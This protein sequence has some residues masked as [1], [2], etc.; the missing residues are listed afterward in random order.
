MKQG[1]NHVSWNENPPES[2]LGK[3]AAEKSKDN[4]GIGSPPRITKTTKVTNSAQ[5]EEMKKK[6]EKLKEEER[7]VD[8]YLDYLKHQAAVYNGRQPP[9]AEHAPYLPPGFGNI[10]DQMYVRFSDVTSMPSY[11]SD[12]VIGIRAPSGTSLEVPDPDQGMMHGERRF[13][14]YL[15]SKGAEGESAKASGKGEPI[16]VYL[17]RPRADQQGKMGGRGN[18]GGFVQQTPPSQ[19]DPPHQQLPRDKGPEED[20]RD[21]TPGVFRPPS[22]PSGD[23]QYGPGRTAPR[24]GRDWDYG[25]PPYPP[26]ENRSYRKDHGSQSGSSGGYPEP[27]W[28]PPPH[29]GF[30]PP[31][32]GYYPP[33]SHRQ[34][35][36][37][38]SRSREDS[39]KH[40]S[41]DGDA[42]TGERSA[43]GSSSERPRDEGHYS[44]SSEHAPGH[45]EGSR[46]R[47]PSASRDR[48]SPFRPRGHHFQPPS[49]EHGGS[50]LPPTGEAGPP[51]DPSS[52]YRP[53]TPVSQQQN[54]L[55]MPLQSPNG[56]FGMP[57]S[58]YPSPSGGAPG[59]SPSG[60]GGEARENM[61]SGEV[62]FPMPPLP[63][64]GRNGGGDYRDGGRWRPP[65]SQIPTASRSM[66]SSA[67][68]DEHSRS[69][70]Q[71]R[72]RR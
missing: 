7:Q 58:Y 63:R 51:R 23:H 59:Y 12:T 46:Q 56:S 38:S 37:A 28:G 55:H 24:G 6:L 26:H 52:A 9:S 34:P 65:R 31:P 33:P 42:G 68:G 3:D 64:D 39:Q 72:P 19:R 4:D 60:G 54:L 10:N 41:H 27:T 21:Q 2:S 1:K 17:V 25:R 14:M 30:G 62:H 48:N 70:P 49:H 43:G 61:Q 36:S 40:S 47:V 32:P 71:S 22:Q 67:P 69:H 44:P 29:G 35:H 20:S 50:E 8:R 16:N 66:S 15:S 57:S 53:P 11:N 45:G 5:Y 13:E 18:S